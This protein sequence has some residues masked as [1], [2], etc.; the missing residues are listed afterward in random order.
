M[1]DLRTFRPMLGPTP[2]I[3]QAN[4]AYAPVYSRSGAYL[5]RTHLFRETRVKT[6]SILQTI[7]DRT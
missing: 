5:L 6:S 7:L 1:P 2:V 3:W 4:A